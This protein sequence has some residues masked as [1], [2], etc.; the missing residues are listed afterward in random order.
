MQAVIFHRL[1]ETAAALA[2]ASRVRLRTQWRDTGLEHPVPGDLWI[3]VM[4]EDATLDEAVR[5]HASLARGLA[6]LLGFVANAVE[7]LEVEL[8]YDATPRR[9][10]REYL[11]AFVREVGPIP[12]GGRVVPTDH[13]QPCVEAL[14][15]LPLTPR[16]QRALFQYDH[17]LRN[18]RLGGEYQSLDH[19]WIAAEKIVELLLDQRAADGDRSELARSL[20]IALDRETW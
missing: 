16:L 12:K 19:L 3:E 18:W 7:P 17:A 1:G 14:L 10:E 2:R 4:G 20:G 13:L 5:R 11:Q 8:A 15:A 6:A 9:T